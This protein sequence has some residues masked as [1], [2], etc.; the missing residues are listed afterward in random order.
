MASHLLREMSAPEAAEY[1]VS[2]LASLNSPLEFADRLRKAHAH[3]KAVQGRADEDHHRTC[4][5][6][7]IFNELELRLT[8]I[9]VNRMGGIILH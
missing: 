4:A 5:E 2:E 8:E 3:I 7:M 9:E 6:E 1:V